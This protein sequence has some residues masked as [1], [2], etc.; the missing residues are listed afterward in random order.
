MTA[1]AA[2]VFSDDFATNPF[3]SRWT[4][5]Q[6]EASYPLYWTGAGSPPSGGL[7]AN[8]NNNSVYSGAYGSYQSMSSVDT[9]V[10]VGVT[11]WT[12]LTYSLNFQ[13]GGTVINN[14]IGVLANR[15]GT[16]GYMAGI[17]TGGSGH[18][19][20]VDAYGLAWTTPN[21]NVAA[22]TW[23]TFKTTLT[24]S[25]TDISMQSQILDLSNTV[26]GTSPIATFANATYLN[27]NGF[28]IKFGHDPADYWSQAS[29]IDNFSVTAVP[30][31][32]SAAL[33]GGLGALF[34]IRRRR[35]R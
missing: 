32:S 5:D 16:N 35:T 22:N 30:E 29:Q 23:Y 12:E 3:A 20:F 11:G 15:S 18:I 1:S 2:T 13:M 26:L 28:Y 19:A 14:Y 4:Y 7:P 24:K 10:P 25:G 9:T 31:P 27:P 33:L 8:A 34:L 21:V 6:S 17:Y